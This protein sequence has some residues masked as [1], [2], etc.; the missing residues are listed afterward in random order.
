MRRGAAYGTHALAT[1]LSEE[2]D[3]LSHGRRVQTGAFMTFA[4]RLAV[5]RVRGAAGA[6]PARVA[7]STLYQEQKHRGE[8]GHTRDTGQ[9]AHGSLKDEPHNHPDPHQRKTAD[10]SDPGADRY[11]VPEKN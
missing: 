4:F 7:Y 2:H 8:P 11:V 6:A 5:G 1:P 3:A 10:R 9:R